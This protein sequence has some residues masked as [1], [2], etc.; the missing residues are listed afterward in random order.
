MI[1]KPVPESVVNFKREFRPYTEIS[2]LKR[3]VSFLGDRRIENIIIRDLLEKKNRH[4][5]IVRHVC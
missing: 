1:E 2:V 5:G 4:H 3:I